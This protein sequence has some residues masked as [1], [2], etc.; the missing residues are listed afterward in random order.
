[1]NRSR[2]RLLTGDGGRISRDSPSSHRRREGRS[3]WPILLPLLRPARP[4]RARASTRDLLDTPRSTPISPPARCRA[5]ATSSQRELE[6]GHR[7]RARLASTSPLAID[8]RPPYHRRAIP[9]LPCCSMC[10]GNHYAFAPIAAHVGKTPPARVPALS[11]RCGKL[12]APGE[13]PTCRGG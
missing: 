4:H 10:S 3:P 5:I 13:S 9:L 7:V 1:M 8:S 12:A 11:R 6:D 2:T